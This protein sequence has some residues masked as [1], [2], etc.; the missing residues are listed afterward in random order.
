MRLL[1]D[2]NLSHRLISQLRDLHPGSEHVRNI[3]LRSVEDISIWEYAQ[4]NDLTIVSKDTDFRHRSVSYGQ[5]PKVIWIGLGN[6]TTAQ[7]E[8]VFRRHHNEVVSFSTDERR[9]LL[10]LA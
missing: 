6:C 3:G 1:F 5:P 7:V 4:E 8:F 10:E 2:Q 9:S